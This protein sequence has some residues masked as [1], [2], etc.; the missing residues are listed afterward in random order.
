MGQDKWRWCSKCQGLAYAG[1]GLGRCPAG[2]MH[3]HSGSWNYTLMHDTS[4]MPLDGTERKMDRL[5][6]SGMRHGLE[7]TE[8]KGQRDWRWCSK[9]QGLAYA[10]NAAKGPCPAGGEH[11][12]K[13]WNYTLMYKKGVPFDDP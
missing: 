1:F 3:N 9:C 10:G 11:N 12:Q 4:S 2:G 13:S 7:S 6:S 5:I 8:N